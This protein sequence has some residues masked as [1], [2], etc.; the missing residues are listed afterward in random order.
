MS[1]DRT[2]TRVVGGVIRVNLPTAVDETNLGNLQGVKPLTNPDEIV[3]AMSD[4]R[5]RTSSEYRL[6]VNRRLAAGLGEASVN[7][8]QYGT[9]TAQDGGPQSG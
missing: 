9:A 4:R 8:D 5:Y 3:A 1:F 6:E 7:A 2:T